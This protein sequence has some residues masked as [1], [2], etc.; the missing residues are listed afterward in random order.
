MSVQHYNMKEGIDL[1]PGETWHP[2]LT[3]T[4]LVIYTSIRDNKCA[5]TDCVEKAEKILVEF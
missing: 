2:E 1:C 4:S 3:E 5:R